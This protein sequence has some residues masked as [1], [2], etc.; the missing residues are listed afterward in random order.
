MSLKR[1]CTKNFT[2]LQ[3]DELEKDVHKEFHELT[4]DF[5]SRTAFG[6]SFE[7]GRQIFKLEE[8]QL[9]LIREAHTRVYIPGFR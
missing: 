2:S 9:H 8:Q 4:A 7:E 6:S 5:I 3:Q 1:M